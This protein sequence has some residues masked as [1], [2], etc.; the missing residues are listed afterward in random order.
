MGWIHPFLMFLVMLGGFYVLWLGWRRFQGLH[1]KQRVSFAWKRHVRIGSYV[2]A[3]W[4]LGPVLGLIG[5]QIVFG[6]TF[7]NSTH[8]WW[9]IAMVPLVITGYA[10]GR[11]LDRVKCRRKWLPLIH[12]VNNLVLV[13]MSLWQTFTGWGFLDVL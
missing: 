1:L 7:I 4:A 5:S 8:A 2:L 12:G 13:V 9:G 11:V 10:T 3:F 6:A